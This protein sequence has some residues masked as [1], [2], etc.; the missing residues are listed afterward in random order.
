MCSFLFIFSSYLLQKTNVPHCSPI[1][2]FLS[3]LDNK[4]LPWSIPEDP[5][6]NLLDNFDTKTRSKKKQH[7]GTATW[8]ERDEINAMIP[9]LILDHI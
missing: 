4:H 7:H 2:S 8:N 5:S 3:F 6:A 9:L 1:F